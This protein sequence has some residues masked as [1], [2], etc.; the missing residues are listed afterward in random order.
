MKHKQ[1]FFSMLTITLWFVAVVVQAATDITPVIAQPTPLPDAQAILQKM[2]RQLAEIKEFSVTIRSDYDAIQAD[3]QSIAFGNKHSVF[4]QRPALL[5]IDSMR[6][7][8]DQDMML[9]DGKVL[10]VYKSQDN[11]YARVEKPG[12][13]DNIVVYLV[14]DLQMTIPLARMWTTTLSQELESKIET[15]SYV[16]EDILLDVPTDHIALRLTDV[17]LQLWVTQGERS[18]LRKVIITY[19]HADG[20]PQFRAEL[21]DWNLKPSFKS[22]LFAWKQPKDAEQIPLLAPKPGVAP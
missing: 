13:V 14:R 6:S 15:V 5:R 21:F 17:D 18:L 9:F 2:T 3:G 22:S 12:T 11:V 19:K 4:L 8:G 10:V 20:Q 16:E 7:D 1:K